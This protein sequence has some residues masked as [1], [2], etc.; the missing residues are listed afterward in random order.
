M[1]LDVIDVQRAI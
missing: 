1:T